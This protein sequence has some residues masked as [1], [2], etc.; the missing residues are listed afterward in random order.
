MNRRSQQDKKNNNSIESDDL[1]FISI[2]FESLCRERI[3]QNIMTILNV[4]YRR[5]S[6]ERESDLDIWKFP[7]EYYYAKK[8]DSLMP[9]S[10]YL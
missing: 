4:S 5:S 8:V 9:L 7:I 6:I 3:Q 2:D 1:N 10:I